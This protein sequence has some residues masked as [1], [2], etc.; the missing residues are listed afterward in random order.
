[1]GCKLLP[2]TTDAKGIVP[3]KLQ[4]VVRENPKVKVLYTIPT[5]SNPTGASTSLERKQQVMEVC[6]FVLI[7]VVKQVIIITKKNKLL[8]CCN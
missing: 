7:F 1:M 3:E 4:Q 5:G 8:N 6:F 2:V